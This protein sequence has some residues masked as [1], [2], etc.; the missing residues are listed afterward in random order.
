M[1]V[2]FPFFLFSFFTVGIATR[3]MS[4]RVFDAR[5]LRARYAAL[6]GS[7]ILLD[8]EM[9]GVEQV[10]RHGCPFELLSRFG[11]RRSWKLEIVE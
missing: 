1:P 6:T 2:F 8:L 10:D 7:L 9:G 11:I 4:A 5:E 3:F